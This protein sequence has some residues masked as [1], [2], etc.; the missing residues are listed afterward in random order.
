MN[1]RARAVTFT[2]SNTRRFKHSESNGASRTE[3]LR[4]QH[5]NGQ[6][7]VISNLMT[8]Q[9]LESDCTKE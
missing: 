6:T 2:A 8:R 9:G 5:R 4:S 1:G 7:I 3:S